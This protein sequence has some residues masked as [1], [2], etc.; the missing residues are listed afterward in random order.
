MI[1]WNRAC[2]VT[3]VICG[4]VITISLLRG[5]RLGACL[6]SVLLGVSLGVAARMAQGKARQ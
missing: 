6:G 1:T 2:I 4:A 5:F 3:D